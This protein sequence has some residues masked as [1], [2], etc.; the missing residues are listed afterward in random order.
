M[1]PITASRPRKTTLGRRRG[2]G[3]ASLQFTEPEEEPGMDGA[4]VF[5]LIS[6]IP[7][8]MARS[9][10]GSLFRPAPDGARIGLVC[11]FL[12]WLGPLDAISKEDQQL[13]GLRST[14]ARPLEAEDAEPLDDAEPLEEGEPLDA[15]D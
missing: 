8:R 5:R 2:A 3:Y 9:Q 7:D 14:A 4:S 6:L 10:S 12:H 11:K 13:L 1:S 15:E